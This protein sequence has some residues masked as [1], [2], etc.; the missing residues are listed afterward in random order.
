MIMIQC[1]F[2]D[3]TGGRRGKGLAFT[4]MTIMG[5]GPMVQ[6]ANFRE[7]VLWIQIVAHGILG[8]TKESRQQAR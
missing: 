2:V 5:F 1:S 4:I 6:V 8:E 7:W 3:E